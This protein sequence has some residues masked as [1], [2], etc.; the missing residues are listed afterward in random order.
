[1]DAARHGA[2]FLRGPHNAHLFA[3]PLRDD[4][5][6]FRFGHRSSRLLFVGRVVREEHSSKTLHAEINFRGGEDGSRLSLN[7]RLQC[8]PPCRSPWSAATP[9]GT[10]G[11]TRRF[12]AACSQWDTLCWSYFCLC[13]RATC[14]VPFW[15]S[16]RSSWQ[17]RPSARVRV[18][19]VV[20]PSF[21]H[22]P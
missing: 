13:M 19:L 22:D 3:A 18:P 11:Q 10:A 4:P 20:V 5:N 1:M 14:S 2:Q 15:R 8:V 12:H 7:R 9:C 17:L 16:G 6:L 21:Q